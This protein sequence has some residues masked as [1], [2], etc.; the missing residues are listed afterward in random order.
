MATARKRVVPAQEL[1]AA[2]LPTQEPTDQ[3]EDRA[4]SG[5]GWRELAMRIQNEPDPSV[6]IELVQELIAK[7]DSE[8]SRRQRRHQK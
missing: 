4:A 6:M 3:P 2:T 7:L 1:P 8:K 5:K